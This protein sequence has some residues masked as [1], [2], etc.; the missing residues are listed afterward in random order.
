MLYPA[1]VI[2]S[3]QQIYNLN[4]EQAKAL[5]QKGFEL[6]NEEKYVTKCSQHLYRI[7]TLKEERE[8][9]R[10]ERIEEKKRQRQELL[11]LDW[12]LPDLK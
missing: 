10:R 6:T 3:L 8:K 9:K 12:E 5:F 11:E 7:R 1:A 4:Q 2:W